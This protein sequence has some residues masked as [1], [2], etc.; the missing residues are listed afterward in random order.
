MRLSIAIG[1]GALHCCVFGTPSATRAC[2]G[3]TIGIKK[4]TPAP[5]RTRGRV[6]TIDSIGPSAHLVLGVLRENVI[7]RRHRSVASES[8]VGLGSLGR[9]SVRRGIVDEV[10]VCPSVRVRKSL[11]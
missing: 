9:K 1:E 6:A 3:G 4:P 5:H 8:A 7:F 10:G 2:G 11:G